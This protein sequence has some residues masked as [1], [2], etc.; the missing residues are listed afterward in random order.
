M[1]K[2]RFTLAVA[3]FAASPFQLQ[4]ATYVMMTDE[5]IADAA[6]VIVH[7][8]V[9]TSDTG[10]SDTE[11]IT[12]Y[13]VDIERVLKG[14]L[15]ASSVMVRVPGGL[16]ANGMELSLPGVPR[17]TEGDEA[18]LFLTPRGDGT[19]RLVELGL[20]VFHRVER[21]GRALALRNLG[22]ALVLDRAGAP[23]ERA[24]DF[25]RFTAWLADR[26]NE[27]QTTVDYYVDLPSGGLQSLYE[28]FTLFE[29][30]GVNLRWLEFD[31]AGGVTWLAHEDG[32]P[33]VPGGGFNEFQTALQAWNNDPGTPINLLYGGTTT[34]TG[35]LTAFDSIN[36]IVFDDPNGLGGPYDCDAGGVLASG[37]SWSI[38]AQTHEFRGTTFITI[39]GGDV[40]TREGV[41][42]ALSQNKLAEETFA[43]EIGHALGL[44]HSCGD[45]D[46][47]P[48]DTVEKDEALMRASEL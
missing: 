30:D 28:R 20:G 7:A 31:S 48:C 47:G 9:V 43:H 34:A 33:G 24:R 37:G 21:P 10:I 40:V 29:T 44:R 4:A 16:L 23:L 17:L 38:P 15:P 22:D 6:P 1:L 19:Y 8:T 5:D 27:L 35:G 11:A 46:S 36:A 12:E 2:F 32:Q 41:G 14:F 18:L 26:A 13:Q 3:L 39:V 45:T 42:C 25:D